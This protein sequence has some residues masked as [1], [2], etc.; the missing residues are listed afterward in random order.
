MLI[1]LGS[2]WL[3]GCGSSEPAE[4]SFPSELFQS[5]SGNI[6]EEKCLITFTTTEVVF[7]ENAPTL[8]IL[9]LAGTLPSSCRDLQIQKKPPD[10]DNLIMVLLTAKSG[11]DSQDPK[12][13]ELEIPLDNLKKGRTYRVWVNGQ[14]EF[15]FTVPMQ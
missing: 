13:F 9:H 5:Q 7:R 10:K 1:L 8:P 3:A 12:P 15:T 11:G 14:D 4:V 2:L 6:S